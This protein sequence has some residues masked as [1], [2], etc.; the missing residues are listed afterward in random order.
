MTRLSCCQGG[1]LNFPGAAIARHHEDRNLH[2][3]LTLEIFQTNH[4]GFTL[5]KT[6]KRY[7][8]SLF[9]RSK[10]RIEHFNQNIDV[11]YFVLNEKL[12]LISRVILE[13]T[14]GTAKFNVN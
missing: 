5:L 12:Q 8:F 3:G 9:G 6:V 10:P 13:C 2:L 7:G 14:L 1:L 11:M 4:N